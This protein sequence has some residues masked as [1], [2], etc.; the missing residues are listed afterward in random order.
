[1]ILASLMDNAGKFTTSGLAVLGAFFLGAVVLGAGTNFISRSL[2]GKKLPASLLRFV[3]V[4][5]GLAVGLAVGLL[6]FSGAGGWGLGGSGGDGSGNAAIKPAMSPNTTKMP[7]APPPARLGVALLGGARVQG[8]AFYLVDGEQLPRTMASMRERLTLPASPAEAQ[9]LL[10]LR[11]YE[12]SVAQ[13]HPA[14]IELETWA[15]QSGW[16]VSVEKVSDM[17]PV[18]EGGRP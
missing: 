18:V 2:F 16:R 4:L 3:R 17:L 10:T 7:P 5:G 1:M 14:V 6:V 8:Q 15:R 11:I 13:D 12:D 9:P